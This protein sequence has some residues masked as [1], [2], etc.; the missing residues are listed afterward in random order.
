MCSDE[1]PDPIK[2]QGFKGVQTLPRQLT[3]E[4]LTKTLRAYPVAET[5]KLRGKQVGT[6]GMHSP[7][8]NPTS[9]STKLHGPSALLR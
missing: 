5:N 4:P 7:V 6:V 1:T 9:C 8:M 3:Y 2:R